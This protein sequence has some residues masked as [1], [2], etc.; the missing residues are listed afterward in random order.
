[1]Y[2]MLRVRRLIHVNAR[3]KVRISIGVCSLAGL[4]AGQAPRYD[5][6]RGSAWNITVVAAMPRAASRP[7]IA[8]GGTSPCAAL[9]S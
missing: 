4:P 9:A 1:M 7:M 8:G 5:I 6:F 3:R 2:R